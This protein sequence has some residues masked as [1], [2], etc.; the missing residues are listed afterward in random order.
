MQLHGF[1]IGKQRVALANRRLLLAKEELRR[2]ELERVVA[3]IEDVAQ[4]DVRHLL[5]EKRRR[6][7][8]A[9]ECARVACFHG[10]RGEQPVAEREHHA[11]VVARVRIGDRLELAPRDA[12]AR[13]RHQRGMEAALG[14]VGFLGRMD[15]RPQVIGAQEIVRDAQASGRISY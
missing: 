3:A 6:V 8:R 12:P 5:D 13:L 11:V 7:H 4:D 15:F 10:P 1:A 2:A 9:P 14:V